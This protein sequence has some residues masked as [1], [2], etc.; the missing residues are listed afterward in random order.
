MDFDLTEIL[1][2]REQHLPGG[3]ELPFQN[4]L[5]HHDAV[6]WGADGRII[7]IFL[8]LSNRDLAGG[9]RGP[10]IPK[11]CLRHLQ[12]RLRRVVGRHGRAFTRHGSGKFIAGPASDRLGPFGFHARRVPRRRELARNAEVTLGVAYSKLRGV[13]RNS[14]ALKRRPSILNLLAGKLDL[15][16]RDLSRAASYIEVSTSHFQP[17]QRCIRAETCEYISGLYRGIVIGDDLENLP[18]RPRDYRD[19]RTQL[20]RPRGTDN[21]GDGSTLHGSE[22]VGNFGETASEKIKT[23]GGKQYERDHRRYNQSSHGDRL[24]FG[25]E[26]GY[27]FPRF[28]LQAK[29]LR[30]VIHGCYRTG[31]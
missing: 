11:L 12:L 24:P 27:G 26:A 31:R 29:P 7:D 19:A 23:Y 14:R 1:G 25:T 5:S 20:D 17:R 15:A 2:Q 30:S 9:K 6:Y 8:G 18:L 16:C 10:R 4:V 22:P 28:S 21:A 3:N 13:H